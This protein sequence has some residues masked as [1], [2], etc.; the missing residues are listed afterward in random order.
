MANNTIRLLLKE[1]RKQGF[2]VI[3]YSSGSRIDWEPGHPV[4]NEHE[5]ALAIIIS[6][7]FSDVPDI[8]LYERVDAL[9]DAM[10]SIVLEGK[11]RNG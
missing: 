4:G 5:D 3:G 1:L 2:P 9:E 8:S 6:S 10:L 11:V 7:D